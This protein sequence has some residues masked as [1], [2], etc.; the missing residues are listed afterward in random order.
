MRRKNSNLFI[1]VLIAISLGVITGLI[2]ELALNNTD[3][4][5][6]TY[7]LSNTVARIFKTFN[8]IFAQFLKFVVPLLV[9]GLVT[10][11]IA[12]E[13]RGAGKMLLVVL[14]VAYFSTICAGF[15]SY[16]CTSNMFPIYLTPGELSINEVAA[17]DIKPFVDLKIPPLCDILTALCLSFMIG[18][19]MIFINAP[20]LHKGFNEFG[21][22][23]KLTIE[24][25]IIPLLPLYI[26][27]M[28]CEMA[29]KG[30]VS[31]VLGTGFKVI[32]T[33][34]LLSILFLVVQYAIAGI[35]AHKNPFKCLWN[36]LPAYLTGFSIC[37]SSA[38]IPVTSECSRK[39]GISDNVVDFTIP[40]CSTVHM[41]GSTIKLAVT[42]I[43]VA[44]VTGTPVTFAVYANFVLLQG[45]AA[46]AAPG[47]MGGV[48]MASIGLLES[49][50]GFNPE[51]TAL[52]MTIYLA[53]DGYGPACNVT[54][55]G[56]IA[57]II[58]RFFGKKVAD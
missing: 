46:V 1:R 7:G 43:A 42:S 25:A 39:N 51:Q 22:V 34:L 18:V 13:G 19:S 53:L 58:E 21:E 55:D 27:T 4:G 2:I 49:I 52:V 12:N 47:V 54:G 26:F 11:A 33:G 16:L 6:F 17:R 29:A 32:L 35:I 5:S 38:V 15:F 10:P 50:M 28:I 45:I 41:C 31:I 40:L 3:S 36:M 30:V 8:V 14:S 20:A 24:K 48:L 23:V 37:S 56:A 9:L 57:L 44:Y